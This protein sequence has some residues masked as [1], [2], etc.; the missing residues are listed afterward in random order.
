MRTSLSLDAERDFLGL[1]MKSG[2][3][4]QNVLSMNAL[5][6]EEISEKQRE[7]A[8]TRMSVSRTVSKTSVRSSLSARL[9]S[10]VLQA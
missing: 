7:D 8:R 6:C 4:D 2:T 10:Y 9:F 3:W 1:V 5:N